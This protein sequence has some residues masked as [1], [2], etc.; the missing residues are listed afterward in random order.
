MSIIWVNE[1]FGFWSKPSTEKASLQLLNEILYAWNNTPVVGDIFCSW[2]KALDCVHHDVLLSKLKFYGV[3][4]KTSLV[5]KLYV[6][7]GHKRVIFN[8]QYA[9]HN[10]YCEWGK[11]KYSVPQGSLIHGPFLFLL[12]IHN[13][14]KNHIYIQNNS[15]CRWHWYNYC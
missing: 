2:E 11:L 9:S 3:T 10:T 15:F 7:V 12:Y 5:I 4:G 1:Q 6:E 13:L 8:D 14:Q